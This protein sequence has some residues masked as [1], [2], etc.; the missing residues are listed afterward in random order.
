MDCTEHGRFPGRRGNGCVRPNFSILRISKPTS[1]P[2][3]MYLGAINPDALGGLY[4]DTH[5]ASFHFDDGNH[6]G[7]IPGF[8]DDLLRFV[9]VDGQHD[10]P[11]LTPFVPCGKVWRYFILRG[12]H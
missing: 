9:A 11:H 6:Y 5:A 2:T 3:L 12:F 4:A 7:A 1:T 8:D 10:A